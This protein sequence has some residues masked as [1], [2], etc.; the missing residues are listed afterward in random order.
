[1][2]GHPLILL[3]HGGPSR[4][5]A[6]LYGKVAQIYFA[7]RGS[8][9]LCAQQGEQTQ[10]IAAALSATRTARRP[11]RHVRHNLCLHTICEK[12]RPWKD[13]KTAYGSAFTLAKT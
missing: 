1:M 5:K 2:D 10:S 3:K 4:K 7:V 9:L 11:P 13:K 8:F 6:S 12:E